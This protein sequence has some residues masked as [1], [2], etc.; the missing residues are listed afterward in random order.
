ME[1]KISELYGS[2]RKGELTRRSFMKKLA[3]FTGSMAGAVMLMPVL[4]EN[5]LMTGK[6]LQAEPELITEMI[7]YPAATVHL[8]PDRLDQELIGQRAIGCSSS[9]GVSFVVCCNSECK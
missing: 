1:K 6:K 4:E 7:K 8:S 9:C 3:A 5:E 2:Y